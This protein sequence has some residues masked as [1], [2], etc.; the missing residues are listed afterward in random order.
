MF[1]IY[2]N[3]RPTGLIYPEKEV[4]KAIA[5]DMRRE[6]GGKITVRPV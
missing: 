5:R 2:D 4:A 3:G 6:S 1:E